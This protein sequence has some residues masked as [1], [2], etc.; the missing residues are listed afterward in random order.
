MNGELYA[1]GLALLWGMTG[2]LL[3]GLS[4]Q[5]GSI[6]LNCL[7]CLG[8]AAAL[9][10]AVIL[11]GG[12]NP[13]GG[14]AAG[15][16]LGVIGGTIITIGI[17]DTLFVMGLKRL[18]YSRAY[19]I[20]ICGYPLLTVLSAWIFL[21][22][23][24]TLLEGAGIFLILGGLLL[25]AFPAGPVF[26]R[27]DLGSPRERKGLLFILLSLVCAAGGTLVLTHF[28]SGVDVLLASFARYAVVAVILAII[29]AREWAGLRRQGV[30]LKHLGLGF[31]NGALA[32]G[33]GGWV[34][35]NSLAGIGAAMTT[36]LTSTSPLFVLPLSVIILKEKLTRKLV[37]GVALSV[38]GV[39][40][41]F[42]PRIVGS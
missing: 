42:L 4:G 28:V 3:K 8:G 13:P 19:P 36:V 18:E 37:T 26:S 17:G 21:G 7:R 25:I 15:P 1:L 10:P 20:Y 29:S 31:L 22:E 40:L 32:L 11:T 16:L 14:I 38:C 30:P 6:F 9:L 39:V 12:F 5:F 27:L 41:V 35:L 2:L 24:V 33:A 34:F 23:K